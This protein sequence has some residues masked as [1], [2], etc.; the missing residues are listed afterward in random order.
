[1]QSSMHVEVVH[2]HR[3]G[4]RAADTM[5]GHAF[6]G[7]LDLSILHEAPAFLFFVLCVD[8]EGG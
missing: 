7:P 8:L 2:I 6:C 5:A 4:N 1:M 3:E